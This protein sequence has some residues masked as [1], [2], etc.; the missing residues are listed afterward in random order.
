MPA[1]EIGA[2]V[3][4]CGGALVRGNPAA[5]VTSYS[6]D[7]R[8]LVA[9]AAFF[10]LRGSR[11]DGH[12][13][14]EEAG[15]A[16]AA[17]VVVEQD[18]PADLAATTAVLRV[19]DATA[20]LGRCAAAARRELR[21]ARVLAITG[22][23]GKTTTK[24]LLAAALAADRKVHKTQANL[25]NELGLPLAILAAP[26]DSEALVLELGM[27]GPG[28]IAYLAR[29]ADPDVGLVTNVR[30]VHLEFFRT[31]DDIAAAKGELFAVMRPDAIAVVNLDDEFVRVQSARH[32]GPRVT[33]GRHDSADL[34]LESVEDRFVPGASLVFRHGARSIRLDLRLAGAHAA[35]NALAALAAVVAAGGE[36]DRAAEAIARVEAGPGRGR[37]IPL[38]HGIVLVDETY[39]SNPSALS[40]VLRTIGASAPPGRKVLV[41]G[42]MLE[43]GPEEAGF[44]RDAGKQAASVGVQVLMGVGALARGAVESGRKAGVPEVRHEPDAAAA[45][46]EMPHLVRPGD[47]VVVKGSRGVHLEQVVS[48]LVEAL[49]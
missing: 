37:V 13:F 49:R 39:N 1:L 14:V 8:T 42:D 29:I 21:G 40:S 45:A 48:A 22:S 47:L 30:P 25:N 9:G 3:A 6:I 31:L 36:L 12:R 23:S 18:P 43:L 2:M 11:S 44:H 20:A 46:R 35:I 38:R 5:R 19:D 15:R 41:L 33:Y 16:G 32:A 34:V 24:E 27:R 28:Q 17:L 10:A 26:D 7:T 4:A